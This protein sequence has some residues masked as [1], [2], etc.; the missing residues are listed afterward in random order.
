MREFVGYVGPSEI[1]DATSERVD[2]EPNRLMVILR[3]GDASGAGLRIEFSEPAEVDRERSV[4][5]TLYALAELRGGGGRRRF[6]FVDWD[7]A[8]AARLELEASGIDWSIVGS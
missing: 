8:D 7:E 5:M 2:A 4:G 1:H 3:S 6:S